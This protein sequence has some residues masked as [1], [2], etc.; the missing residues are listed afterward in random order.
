MKPTTW[1][2][3]VALTLAALWA[4]T[5]LYA[6]AMRVGF[7]LE[8]EWM[9]GGVL[10]Q[11]TRFSR[12]EP[13]YPPPSID[14]VP[15]LYTPGYPVLLGVLGW[16]L[17]G[18]GLVLGRL[19]SIVATGCSAWAI[20]RAIEGE[21]RPRLY[22]FVGAGLFLA[23][24]VFTFRWYDL[25]RPDSTYLALVLWA[26][27]RLRHA[28]DRRAAIVAGVLMALAFWTKQTAASFVI[29]SGLGALLVAPRQ[30]PWYAATI[31][32]IDG[33]GVLVGNA[34]TDGWL[35]TY[36]YELHQTH[37][38]NR[39]RF[40]TKTWGMF[41][42]AAPWLVLWLAVAAGRLADTLRRKRWPS[43]T[44]VR[45][46]GYWWLMAVA[47]LL[48][49]ALG[50]S[51]AWAEPNAFIP[52]VALSAIA[53]MLSVPTR[54]RFAAV[55]LGF[56]SAQL[57]FAWAVEPMYQPIQ[58]AGPTRASIADSYTW[59]EA[60][61]TIP[62][63]ERRD[64]AAKLRSEIEALASRGEVL[65]LHRPWWSVIAGGSGHVGSMGVRDVAPEDQKRLQ[66]DL[67]TS[68]REGR[69]EVL[70]FEGEPPSWLSANIRRTYRVQRRLSGE[71]RVRPMSGWMSEAG[72]VTAYR[73]DQV[74]LVK[75]GER[76][77]PQ[78][79]DVIVDFETHRA[80]GFSFQGRAFGRGPVSPPN[81]RLPWP[82]PY[83]GGF[84]LSSA[85]RRGDVRL[86]G[87]ATTAP[88]EVHAGDQL[89]MLLGVTRPSNGLRVVAIAGDTTYVIE[90]PA[91]PNAL[92]TVVFDVPADLDGV[93]MQVRLEDE[94]PEA[95]L[96]FD[97][98]WR[99]P[100]VSAGG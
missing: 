26:L 16:P 91:Q 87:S 94:A 93:Q 49:S 14:F 81:G 39:E 2:Q 11:A 67:R 12:G 69:W 66:G 10:H 3:R 51:T 38:F 18:P 96:Y 95:A 21:G 58:D 79:T 80:P 5:L 28:P 43:L 52:G 59:Q 7:A 34:L 1:P 92:D 48:V 8:L 89:H 83:G 17:G 4:L 36:I 27:V 60:G 73:R 33:G 85:G 29:A 35:W 44:T 32:V 100:S 54:G 55:G 20:V 42:H 37:A 50:Y 72:V 9:E 76:P 53:V 31:A 25:A 23:G 61:R 71:A 41:A 45:T 46:H 6:F 56:V 82:G 63:A 90:L 77:R 70:W 57:A 65:A 62:S 99:V 64:A 98:L 24:Y 97:D 19:V 30:L 78:G 68:L 88:F 15:F 74:M 22:G 84:L 13:I 86:T 40:T 47:G 75:K